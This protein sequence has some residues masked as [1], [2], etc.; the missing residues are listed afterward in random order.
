MHN[1]VSILENEMHK[2]LWDFEIQTDYLI[3]T[4]RSDLITITQKKKKI[5]RI[6]DFAVTADC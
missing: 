2:C 1:L 5:Y 6:V 3:S 4:R